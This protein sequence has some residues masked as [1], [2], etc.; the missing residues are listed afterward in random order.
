MCAKL[1]EM[2]GCSGYTTDQ[3]D[4]AYIVHFMYTQKVYIQ[5]MLVV[6][7]SAVFH[8]DK[9]TRYIQLMHRLRVRLFA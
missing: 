8:E 7:F 1:R 9:S 3:S 5:K 4:I 6:H 2:R